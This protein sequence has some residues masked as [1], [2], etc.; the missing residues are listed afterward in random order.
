MLTSF[1]LSTVSSQCDD[2]DYSPCDC[3][4]LAIT[5]TKV[6][7]QDVQMIFAQAPTVYW[8][9]FDWSLPSGSGSEVDVVIQADVL[10]T[11]RASLIYIACTDPSTRLLFDSN[12]FRYSSDTTS[13]ISMQSCDLSLNDRYDFLDGFSQ[14]TYLYMDSQ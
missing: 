12:A 3:D 6:S 7:A 8:S 10:N 1:T 5:C 2:Y 9:R 4:Y 14:L 11:S 13:G